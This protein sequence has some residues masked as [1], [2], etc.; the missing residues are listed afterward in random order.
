MRLST[1]SEI[2]ETEGQHARIAQRDLAFLGACVLVFANGEECALVDR[3][4]AAIARRVF[5]FEAENGDTGSTVERGAKGYQGRG[6]E[7]RRI[8]VE[9]DDIAGVALQGRAGGE[10]RVGGA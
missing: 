7:Q 4:Q 2:G 1:P 9:D 5:G 6:F 8:G 10:D 3:D